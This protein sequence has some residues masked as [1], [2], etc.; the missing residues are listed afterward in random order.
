MNPWN[1]KV[2]RKKVSAVRIMDAQWVVR[3]FVLAV[4]AVFGSVW[5]YR[6]YHSTSWG[7]A[8]RVALRYGVEHRLLKLPIQSLSTQ[9][10]HRWHG[11]W[12]EPYFF[13]ETPGSQVLHRSPH[14]QLPPFLEI[15]VSGETGTVVAT[16]VS[17]RLKA[18]YPIQGFDNH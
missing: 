10:R 14:G 16:D 8:Q 6:Y 2:T 15:T 3:V 7:T 13:F 17:P 5:T 12:L 9:A 18:S 1:T 11:V 4:L